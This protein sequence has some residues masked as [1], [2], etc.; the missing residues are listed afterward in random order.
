M[1]CLM[2]STPWDFVLEEHRELPPEQQP[3][4][5]LRSLPTRTISELTTMMQ[6]DLGRAMAVVVQ[7]GLVGW[8]NIH[9]P[10]GTPA[11]FRP[12]SGRR[13]LY[14]V[15]IHGGASGSCVDAIPYSVVSA[16]AGAILEGNRVD[17]ESAKN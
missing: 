11:Q 14:G 8:R 7:A 2:P 9:N 3:T 6:A 13:V 17:R 4:W 12:H 15:E 10:D 16:L 5:T 1:F